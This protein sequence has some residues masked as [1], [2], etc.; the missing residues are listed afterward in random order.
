MEL[1]LDE[2]FRESSSVSEVRVVEKS[3]TVDSDQTQLE[4]STTVDKSGAQCVIDEDLVSGL[5]NIGY[6]ERE[7][8]QRIIKATRKL[9]GSSR[10][11][12]EEEILLSALQG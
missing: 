11:P 9:S 6:P 8:R 3:T 2:E 4:K 1:N 12:K 10:K 5:K 7:A